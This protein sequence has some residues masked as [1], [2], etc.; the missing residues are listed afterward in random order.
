[1][2]V[3]VT[4][5]LASFVSR[6]ILEICLDENMRVQKRWVDIRPIPSEESWFENVWSDFRND[7]IIR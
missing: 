3:A 5:P 2:F 1:M 4:L 7:R 6:K